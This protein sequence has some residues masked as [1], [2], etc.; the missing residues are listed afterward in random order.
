VEEGILSEQPKGRWLLYASSA[1]SIPI[2]VLIALHIKGSTPGET[3]E[4]ALFLVSA[5]AAGVIFSV[6]SPIVGS[7]VVDAEKRLA[8][9]GLALG[10]LVGIACLSALYSALLVSYL[11]KGKTLVD[12]INPEWISA[13]PHYYVFAALFVLPIES[14]VVLSLVAYTIKRDQKHAKTVEEMEEKI[15]ALAIQRNESQAECAELREKVAKMNEQFNA[16][17]REALV[18]RVGGQ[19]K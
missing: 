13:N 14:I 17:L 5:V 19:D 9:L 7:A 8:K 11:A 18:A 6:G 12:V 4:T 10:W 1:A 15:D 16:R 3:A 2:V